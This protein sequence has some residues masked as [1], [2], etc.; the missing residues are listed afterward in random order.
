MRTTFAVEPRSFAWQPGF[1]IKTYNAQHVTPVAW[2]QVRSSNAIQWCDAVHLTWIIHQ[3]AEQT[4]LV[5]IYAGNRFESA[6]A[7]AASTLL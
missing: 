2:R 1:N 6:A 7:A 5:L 4:T 3:Q